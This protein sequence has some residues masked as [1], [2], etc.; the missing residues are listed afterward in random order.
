MITTIATC[1]FA[2]SQEQTSST[3]LGLE[4]YKICCPSRKM[5][6]MNSCNA[7]QHSTVPAATYR[8]KYTFS[9]RI[10]MADTTHG[11][12]M[13]ITW[14]SHGNHMAITL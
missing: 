5:R 11:N 4:T 1:S 12:H 9:M 2:F 8:L 13:A 10:L 7:L 6:E 3:H 14:Q